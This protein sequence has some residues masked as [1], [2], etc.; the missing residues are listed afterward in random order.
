MFQDRA[1]N[2]TER[3]SSTTTL[4][5]NVKD[6]DDQD[7]S[8]VYQG[9]A[10]QDSACVNPEYHAIVSLHILP[11]LFNKFIYDQ[12]VNILVLDFKDKS[13]WKLS[14]EKKFTVNFSAIIVSPL[15]LHEWLSIDMFKVNEVVASKF[16]WK[17][18]HW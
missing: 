9:C 18:N 10:L 4:T 8:F 11:Q 16:Y 12:H 6:E 17:I 14:V 3:L 5:V 2:Q 15:S 7:P 1:R 13:S